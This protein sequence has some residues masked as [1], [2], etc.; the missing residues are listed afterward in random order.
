MINDLMHQFNM[1]A[2]VFGQFS[3]FYYIGYSLMHIPIGIL[4]DRYSPRIIMAMCILLTT[5]G[6]LP[7]LFATHWIW[8]LLGRLLIGIGSSAAVLG[9]FK[10]IRLS[11]PENKFTKMLSI[12]VTIGLIGAIY[13]GGPIS[14]LCF[15]YGYEY[16]V[17][18]LA[19]AGLALTT[20]IYLTAPHQQSPQKESV[21]NN[22][23][24]VLKNKKVIILCISSGFLVGPLEGF[25]D[26]WGSEF[27]KRIY[28]FSTSV[29]NSLPASIFLGMCFGGPILSFI[30]ERK[31]SYLTTILSSG[32]IMFA[33]FT[34]LVLHLLPQATVGASFV[35]VGICCAYQ[36]IAIYKASTYVP[37][38]ASGLAT[39]LA[40][41]I[42][43]IFGYAFHSVIGLVISAYK[44]SPLSFAYGISVI[45]A[46]LLIGCVGVIYV[47]K[48]DN[49]SKQK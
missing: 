35:L 36:I 44:S 46:A 14:H 17:K 16:V 1:D 39:A 6:T 33:A 25:S 20:I 49:A 40:N 29:A 42:I 15:L 30:A 23:K 5:I 2:K 3:G 31:N 41:M 10:I 21:Y 18:L 9:T 28:G 47:I 27:L 37:E 11:F 32:G 38:H 48:L 7:I 45:P 8:P 34:L 24:L 13:G 26:V 4:L 22:L 12:S 43:M 19:F